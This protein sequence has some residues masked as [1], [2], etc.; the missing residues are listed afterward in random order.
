MCTGY[1]LTFSVDT[2]YRYTVQGFGLLPIKIV[3][4]SQTGHVVGYGL[5]S[6]EDVRAHAFLFYQLK[7]ECEKTVEEYCVKGYFN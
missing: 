3:D 6:K 5:V 1:D 2:S 7:Y 4:F